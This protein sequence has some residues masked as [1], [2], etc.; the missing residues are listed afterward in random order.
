MQKY[1]CLK[2]LNHSLYDSLVNDFICV[3]WEYKMA[4]TAGHSC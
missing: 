1:I 3:D 2:P 4:T